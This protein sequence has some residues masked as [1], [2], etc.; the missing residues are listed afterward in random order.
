MKHHAYIIFALLTAFATVRQVSAQTESND[1]S[2]TAI[3]ITNES[4]ISLELTAT[5]REFIAIEWSLD[6]VTWQPV[7]WIIVEPTNT[8]N[9]RPIYS[10]D[11][12]GSANIPVANISADT[13]KYYRAVKWDPPFEW[14]SPV[15]LSKTKRKR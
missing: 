11:E 9:V 15:P 7:E 13:R 6:L 8:Y 4:S 10:V 5:P 3:D 1:I 14:P 2:F 12:S